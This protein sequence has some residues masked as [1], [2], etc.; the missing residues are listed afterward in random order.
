MKRI[1]IVLLAMLL[2]LAPALT[3]CEEEKKSSKRDDDDDEDE[4]VLQDDDENSFDFNWGDESDESDSGLAPEDGETVS[5]EVSDE[6]SGETS[7]EISDEEQSNPDQPKPPVSTFPLEDKYFGET[8]ICV[9]TRSRQ[10]ASQFAGTE[11][12]ASTLVDAAVQER[13]ALLK[14]KYG[15]VITTQISNRPSTDIF[16]CIMT[17]SEFYHVVSDAAYFMTQQTIDGYF[18]SL[19]HLLC[20]DQ[21]WWDQSAINQLNLSDRVYL[22][23]GDAI[24]TDDMYTAA[25]LF[26][27]EAYA[28]NFEPIYGS[29]YD[30]V[31]NGKWTIDVM[32]EMAKAYSR[33]DSSV[34][35]SNSLYLHLK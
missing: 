12:F 28:A 31:G 13:N 20:L 33:P 18:H 24:I 22:V 16:E 19:N 3:A 26:N 30:L 25:V 14:E 5:G 11:E 8:E 32:A 4:E 15:I 27:K 6:I 21:P 10:Y 23:A 7:G 1:L 17:G 9:L 34:P 2:I 29:L 35:S